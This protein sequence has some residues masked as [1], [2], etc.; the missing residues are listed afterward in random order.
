MLGLLAGHCI[1]IFLGGGG[2]TRC[3]VVSLDLRRPSQSD[4][5]LSRLCCACTLFTVACAVV[6]L[7]VVLCEGCAIVCAPLVRNHEDWQRRV[8]HVWP[9]VLVAAR[10][11]DIPLLAQ[12]YGAIVL[13]PVVVMVAMAVANLRHL[14][15][16]LT[17]G[18]ASANSAYDRLWGTVFIIGRRP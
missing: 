2:E 7:I 8:C 17:V 18:L 16:G 14:A 6:F 5:A 10:I 1:V 9:P 15:V 12:V 4:I 3:L 13:A 11:C